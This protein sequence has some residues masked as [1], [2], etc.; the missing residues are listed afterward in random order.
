MSTDPERE[1]EH[2]T[3]ELD[4]R[5]KTLEGHI[6]QAEEKARDADPRGDEDDE[7]DKDTA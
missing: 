7:S 6:E 5:L 2:T 3:E 1:L 4:E